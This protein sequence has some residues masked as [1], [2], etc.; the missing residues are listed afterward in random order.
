[1]MTVEEAIT[2]YEQRGGKRGKTA[3]PGKPTYKMVAAVGDRLQE[4]RCGQTRE[5]WK[6][7]EYICQ[8]GSK[9]V[10]VHLDAKTNI[11]SCGDKGYHSPQYSGTPACV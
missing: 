2:F 6:Y 9:V 4:C 7:P 3:Q 1:M 5:G 10:S 8:V 11:I